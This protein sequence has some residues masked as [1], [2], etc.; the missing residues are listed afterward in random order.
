M[1]LSETELFNDSRFT[2]G[3][4]TYLNKS[5]SLSFLDFKPIY[6][7]LLPGCILALQ[8][9][10]IKKAMAMKPTTRIL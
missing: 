8:T 10:D 5:L 4:Q 9:K 3:F 2:V 6:K 1:L 7:K